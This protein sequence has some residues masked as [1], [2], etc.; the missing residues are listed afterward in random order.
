MAPRRPRPA[1]Q[2]RP[3][4][5]PSRPPAWARGKRREGAS[6]S[7]EGCLDSHPTP[8]AADLGSCP[9]ATSIESRS[10]RYLLLPFATAGLESPLREGRWTNFPRKS[11]RDKHELWLLF[12]LS[13][14]VAILP[15]SG[16]RLQQTLSQRIA[17]FEN[18]QLRRAARFKPP[19]PTPTALVYSHHA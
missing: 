3:Q 17:S 12:L 16:S 19:Q 2:L 4:P 14:P 8:A 11:E 1:G 15:R 10:F 18:E 7:E 9:A 13:F 5:A 6:R